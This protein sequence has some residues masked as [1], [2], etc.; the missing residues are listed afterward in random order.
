MHK[1]NCR[2]ELQN[3]LR[4]QFPGFS[5]LCA[6]SNHR[7]FI[8]TNNTRT[9]LKIIFSEQLN[10]AWMGSSLNRIQQKHLTRTQVQILEVNFFFLT[11]ASPCFMWTVRLHLLLNFEGVLLHKL[12][13]YY[14]LRL[15]VKWFTDFCWFEYADN[16][17]IYKWRQLEP[18]RCGEVSIDI[19]MGQAWVSTWVSQMSYTVE[20]T[21][22]SPEV[23]VYEDNAV[24]SFVFPV[25]LLWLT[26]IG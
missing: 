20:Y 9:A 24:T 16:T 10:H 3:K 13:H 23:T 19:I 7:L 12:A 22:F 25:K 21:Q 11:Q 26:D 4:P 17:S 2:F 5:I 18:A 1:I 15:V 6:W 8:L 14:M